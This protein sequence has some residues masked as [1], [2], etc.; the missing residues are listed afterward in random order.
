MQKIRW[1]FLVTAVVLALVLVFQNNDAVEIQLLF[2][3]QS[4]PLSMLL[5]SST[6]AGFLLGA[7]MTATMLRKRKHS[8]KAKSASKSGSRSQSPTPDPDTNPLT[9][10]E[11]G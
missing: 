11:A 2:L 4:L 7:V 1:F 10:G 5:L 6:A 8:K 9:S 3:R